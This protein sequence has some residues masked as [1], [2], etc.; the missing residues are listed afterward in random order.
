M[1]RSIPPHWRLLA[2]GKAMS[3][4]DSRHGRTSDDS[5]VSI[6]TVA[7][8]YLI[9]L[10]E[11]F[12][13]QSAGVAAPKLGPAF[14]L[15]S[16]QLGWFFSSSTFGLMLGAAI[17]GR[18]S[19][20]FGRKRVLIASVAVFGLMS[21]ATGLAPNF[22]MLLIARFLTGLGIGGALPNLV[23]LVSENSSPTHKNT[24]IGALYAGLPSGGA[25]VSLVAALGSSSDWSR[26]FF[27]G[28]IAP[29][30]AIPLLL[31]ALPESRE[32]H[33]P[34]GARRADTAA[35]SSILFALFGDGRAARTLPL[36]LSFFLALLT[37]YLLLNWLPTLL[38]SRGMSKAD[39]S[40]VQLSFNLFGA[41]ASVCTGL[42]MDRFSLRKVVIGSFVSAALCLLML[43][44]IIP[45]LTTALVV[46]GLVGMT[47]SSTQALMYAIAPSVYPTEIRGTGVG[48]AVAVGRLGSAAGPLLA[49]VLLTGGGT[50]RSVLQVLVPVMLIAGAST[51]FLVR[52]KM[53][54][55]LSR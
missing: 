48:S 45:D 21:V 18:L 34:E 41:L 55:E 25:F 1:R 26:I 37:M 8:C 13:L 46:G 5:R 32:L 3:T 27:F 4:I 33:V 39:A 53:R 51:V 40:L 52:T 28:G 43:A 49:A 23:A 11:G 35:R 9:A 16:T 44:N 54:R 29:L 10:F 47:M 19:D 7:L 20:R 22:E 24:S 17:G 14:H 2:E 30:V 15:Q 12:D 6:I 42:M 38:V 50:A 31:F 36:W